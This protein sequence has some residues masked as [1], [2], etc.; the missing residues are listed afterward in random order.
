MDEVRQQVL[1]EVSE[2]FVGPRDES[3]KLKV[4]A[5]LETYIAGVLHPINA[6]EEDEDDGE[7]D[8][9]RS[10]EGAEG[11]ENSETRKM[12]RQNSIGLRVHL[13][14][15]IRKISVGIDYARYF[16]NED[17][18]YAR[19]NLTKRG[20]EKD[21][22]IDFGDKNRESHGEISI[23]DKDG[24]CE[25]KITWHHFRSN[26]KEDGYNVLNVFLE[27]TAEWEDEKD[28]A[29][30]HNNANSLFQPRMSL[31]SVSNNS[32]FE[33]ISHNAKSFTRIEDEKF[34]VLYKN[35][36][37]FGEGY[38]C[39]AEW[40]EDKKEPMYVRTKII[41]HFMQKQIE[42]F[43]PEGKDGR[44]LGIDMFELGF[45]DSL[46]DHSGNRKIIKERLSPI[47]SQYEEWIKQKRKETTGERVQ[48]INLDKCELALKRMK[49]GLETLT[50]DSGEDGIKILK[51]FVLAN[52]AMVYQRLH[53]GYALQR[54]KGIKLDWPDIRKADHPTWFPFQIAFFLMS[55]NGI[56][57]KSHDD[58]KVADL[59]WFPTGG[60]KTEAYLGVAAFTMILR[61]LRGDVVEGLGVSVI[62][63]YTLR[64]LTL[65]QFE[66]ASTLICALE[67]IRR[68]EVDGKLGDEP[69]LLGLW[70]GYS[71][72]PNWWK[73]S[74]KILEDY[75]KSAG[76]YEIVKTPNGS[77]WQ[78]SYCPWCGEKITPANYDVNH[79]TK[80][81]AVRCS[82]SNGRC[83]FTD[84]KWTSGKVLPLVTVDDDIYYRCPSMIISTVDKFARMPFRQ[85]CGNIFGR[86]A[87]RCKLHGFL[88]ENKEKICKTTSTGTHLKTGHKIE[89][90]NE[91]FPPDLFIQ[92][93]LHLISGP[94]GTMVGLYETAVEYLC[95]KKTEDGNYFK[96][97]IIASTATVKGAQEQIKKIFNV[98]QSLEFPPPGI[99]RSDS[100]FWWETENEGKMFAGMSF[101]RRSGKYALARAYAAM[102]QRV[103]IL[104]TELMNDSSVTE[105]EKNER[106][107]SEIDPYW[108]TVG[109]YNSIREL[110]GATRLVE[111]DVKTNLEHLGKE[112]HPKSGVIRNIGTHERGV[113]ELTGRK[114]QS[115]INMIRDKLERKLPD[116]DV[117]SVLLA[118]NMISVGVDIERLAL[119]LVNGHPKSATEYI[120]A[121]GRI[122]RRNESPGMVFTLYNPYK[123]RD[124]SQYENFRGFH[125]MMQK[126]VE[127]STLTPF[128]VRAYSRAIH[129]AFIAMARHS[130][131]HLSEN[132]NADDFEI[133]DCEEI[134]EFIL[135]R[136]KDIEDVDETHDSYKKFKKYLITF[137]ENW[138]EFIDKAKKDKMHGSNG[139]WYEI[140]YAGDYQT[141]TENKYVLMVDF[142]KAIETTERFP[143]PT[144]GSLREVEPQ[145]RMEY[146]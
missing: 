22:E 114:T 65:Q 47:I 127:E 146:V 100:F 31:N 139:V 76:D 1:D 81:T 4:D 117:I 8:S 143:K 37:I 38:S 104:H 92:D 53:F 126:F 97:K 124:L 25:S 13:K 3:E 24:K 145:I 19:N 66:R 46:D 49:E 121:T 125:S 113:E 35:K 141:P 130:I 111:D 102:L 101:S 142:S 83:I 122:G 135:E 5:P 88:T 137:Q 133:D 29:Y 51:A 120:Q 103:Q 82:N 116:E 95:R 72:T 2:F 27:N 93:E 9:G 68:K 28:D 16:K 85:E 140:K 118:T 48:E 11:E 23:N 15:E 56:A 67:Q 79:H 80:M 40:N 96:P 52:R 86:A 129:A 20:I 57:N 62:M 77:P 63:R 50:E 34:D 84:N 17:G 136:F 74:E 60:G 89:R 119:M 42:K 106:V 123:P 131:P 10:E 112:I 69:F 71:L 6:P 90:I 12:L 45:F 107:K 132:E 110:G 64:L 26:S 55:I 30:D 134:T 14:H 109:Y 43:S 39:A 91:N 44:P 32:S 58:S 36:K 108:T 87:R 41:P 115:E 21:F 98:S 70:V 33:E 99:D 75:K 128:S 59:I 61:R 105:E 18:E 7:S 144:P 54:S 73:N 94:L 138:E 78:N